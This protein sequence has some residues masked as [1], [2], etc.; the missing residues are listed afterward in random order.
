MKFLRKE[1]AR[2]PDLAGLREDRESKKNTRHVEMFSNVWYL[3][4]KSVV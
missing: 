3:D 2:L 4:R 1:K